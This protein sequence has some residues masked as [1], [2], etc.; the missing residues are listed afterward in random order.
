[1]LTSFHSEA[2]KSEEAEVF[3]HLSRASARHAEEHEP[4]IDQL[5]ENPWYVQLGLALRWFMVYRL[6]DKT[7]I[8]ARFAQNLVMG[9]LFGTLFWQIPFNEAYQKNMLFFNVLQ[10]SAQSAIPEVQSNARSRNVYYKHVDQGFYKAWQLAMAQTLTSIPFVCIDVALFG[11]LIYFLTG[12]SKTVDSYLFFVAI[13]VLYGS[14]MQTVMGIFPYLVRDD[15]F[16]V[17]AAVMVLI[18]M[19]LVSGVVATEDVIPIYLKPL[20]YINPLAWAFRALANIEFLSPQYD[21]FPC[22]VSLGGKNLTIP[23]QCGHFFLSSRQIRAG[24]E[25]VYYAIAVLV[26]FLVVFWLIQAWALSYVRF[27]RPRISRSTEKDQNKKWLDQMREDATPGSKII[28]Q[29]SVLVDQVTLVVSDLGYSIRQQPADG[30][31]S[32]TRRAALVDV[33]LLKNVS[34]WALPGLGKPPC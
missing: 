11:N 24:W 6:R 29:E 13:S 20:F 21:V 31:A 23:A 4:D 27:D 32:F 28:R 2:F 17:V 3:F 9:L 19:I 12:L 5:P 10:F 15:N 18:T 30:S 34:M 26:G 8:R 16:A 14:T 33:D 22:H 25:Y 7:K 1:M